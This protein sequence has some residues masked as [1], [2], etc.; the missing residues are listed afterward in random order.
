KKTYLA[1]P[2]PPIRLGTMNRDICR[3]LARAFCAC[4]HRYYRW[5]STAICVLALFLFAAMSQAAPQYNGSSNLLPSDPSWHWSYYSLNLSNPFTAVQA[6]ATAGGGVT[7]LDTTPTS[8]DAAGFETHI[9]N[10]LSPGIAYTD[11]DVVPL[12]RSTGFE[13]DFTVK[14]L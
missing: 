7:T 1:G 3:G 5:T 13:L 2:K 10:L 6:T 12:N 4:G 14:L 11:P 8:S 9:S